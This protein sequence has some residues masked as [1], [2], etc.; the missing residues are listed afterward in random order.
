MYDW[1]N[2]QYCIGFHAKGNYLFN[3]LGGH[4]GMKLVGIGGLGEFLGLEGDRVS[5]IAKFTPKVM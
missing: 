4:K 5:E 2:T 1:M 3:M